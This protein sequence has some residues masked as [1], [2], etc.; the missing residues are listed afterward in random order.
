MVVERGRVVKPRAA[1]LCDV[2]PLFAMSRAS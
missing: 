2:A 1:A